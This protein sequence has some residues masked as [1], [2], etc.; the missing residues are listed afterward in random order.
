VATR[1]WRKSILS[2]AT[3]REIGAA[4]RALSAKEHDLVIDTQG[5]LRTGLI[6]KVSRG[7]RHG[8]DRDSIREPLASMFYDVRHRVGRDLHAIERNRLLTAAALGYKPD[9]APDYGLDRERFRSD[10]PPYAVFLHATAR[11]EK[12]WPVACWVELAAALARRDIDI[13]LPW[14]SDTERERA[15]AIAAQ[16]PNTKVAEK[17]DLERIAGLIAGAQFV[18]G[19]DTGLLHLAAAFGVPLAGCHRAPK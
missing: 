11:T 5:L 13:V 6:A 4:R 16:A 3:W 1:R 8:Y 9:G 17:M 7:V 19:V 2:P 10:A 14:G 15:Q 18:A 12:E